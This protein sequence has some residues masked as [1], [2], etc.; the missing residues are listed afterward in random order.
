MCFGEFVCCDV[1]SEES[2]V[3]VCFGVF[4]LFARCFF[5]VSD[6]SEW[7]CKV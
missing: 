6:V 4:V 2:G 1:K 7:H 3:I 5:C